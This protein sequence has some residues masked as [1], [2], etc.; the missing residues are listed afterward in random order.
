MQRA[1]A[2]GLVGLT[3]V[4]AM[5]GLSGCGSLKSQM[6]Q[7]QAE[8]K[9]VHLS[10]E[11]ASNNPERRE[12]KWVELDQLS[13]FKEIRNEFDYQMNVVTFDYGSKNGAAFV[14]ASTDES[15]KGTWQ[16]NNT[17]ADAFKNEKFVEKYWNSDDVRLGV[18]R[19]ANST[20]TDLGNM[21]TYTQFLAGANAY[22]NILPTNVDKTS[23]LFNVLTRAEVMAATFRSNTQVKMLEDDTKYVA[24]LGKNDNT[25]YAQCVFDNSYLKYD[26]GSLNYDT[27]NSPIT[28]AEVVYNLMKTYYPNELANVGKVKNNPFTDCKD[29][30]DL[31]KKLGIKGGHGEQAYV[32][33]YSL[34]YP[35]RGIDRELYNALYLAY[36]KG[37]VASTS[38]VTNWNKTVQ[39]GN[40]ITYLLNTLESLCADSGRYVVDAEVGT[41]Q[42][43]DLYKQEKLEQEQR[44][45]SKTTIETGGIEV[46]KVRDL[47][48]ID[49][50]LEQLPDEVNMTESEIEEAKEL[51]TGY[52]FTPMDAYMQVDFCSGLNVRVGPSTDFRMIDTVPKGTKAHVVARCN[53]NGWYRVLINGK[54]AYQCGIY[55]SELPEEQNTG[56]E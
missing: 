22:F 20:F 13:T 27:Y 55:F 47:T 3:A 36:T 9:D 7:W 51:A 53:E 45:P 2:I 28:V 18:A 14:N 39:G 12:V 50:L 48:K 31:A 15:L 21:N 38:G 40:Y 11:E 17:L 33:E 23:G 19:K 35:D 32:L 24:T 42:G 29:G 43:V 30:G 6:K 54:I 26:N 25:K 52:T 37:I 4:S 56:N 5:A 44:E 10:V 41:N 34:Q 16:G 1:I 49:D 8:K 46:T